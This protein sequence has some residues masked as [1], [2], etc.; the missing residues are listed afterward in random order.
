[1]LDNPIEFIAKYGVTGVMTLM[2]WLERTERIATQ[3]A[4]QQL[5]PDGIKAMVET[6]NAVRALRFTLFN[7]GKNAK[8]DD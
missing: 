5:V 7:G 8:D 1:M 2:W 6:A 4:L 3:R